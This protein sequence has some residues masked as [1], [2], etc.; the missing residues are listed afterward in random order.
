[1][2]ATDYASLAAGVLTIRGGGATSVDVITLAK[3]STDLS[4][5]IDVSSDFLGG[6]NLAP[7]T[8]TFP[9]ASIT[10]INLQSGGAADTI[11]INGL[12]ANMPLS[13]DSGDAADT[14]NIGNGNLDTVAS[15]ITLIDAIVGDNVNVNDTAATLA[16]NV[17]LTSTT[18]TGIGASTLA[19]NPNALATLNVNGGAKGNTYTV[20]GAGTLTSDLITTLN[21][22]NGVDN[23]FVKATSSRLNVYGNN[24]LDNVRIGDNGSLAAILGVMYVNN[25]NNRSALFIDDFANTTTKNWLFNPSA[26]SNL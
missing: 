7:F 6:G 18:L 13:L 5:T 17:T 19:Y 12:F 10:S 22:G 25:V 2:A 16:R 1:M 23:I 26:M 14:I 8:L 3:T 24:G 4:L 11:N 20:L 21:C 15:N 9:S